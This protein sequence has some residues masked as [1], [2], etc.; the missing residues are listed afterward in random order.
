MIGRTG[1]RMSQEKV[2]GVLEWKSPQSLIEVQQ[3]L[4]FA[5]FYQRFIGDY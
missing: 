2:E 4:G 5:N 3:F 1:I